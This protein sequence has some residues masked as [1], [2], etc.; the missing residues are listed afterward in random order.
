MLLEPYQLISQ[1]TLEPLLRQIAEAT[2]RVTVRFGCELTSF[3]QDGDG[4]T[5]TVRSAAG[6]ERTVR[7]CRS[8][9]RSST[10]GSGPNG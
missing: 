4:V 3:G 2:P 7:A 1:Y 6:Q 9:T 8:C 10:S 5:A